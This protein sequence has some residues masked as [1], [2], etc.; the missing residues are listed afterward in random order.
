MFIFLMAFKR[1]VS[2]ERMIAVI[3]NSGMC[4]DVWFHIPSV[5]EYKAYHFLRSHL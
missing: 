5:P 2:C 3:E 4:N 1:K